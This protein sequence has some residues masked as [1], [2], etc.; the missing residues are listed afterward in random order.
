MAIV[1]ARIAAGD[2]AVAKRGPLDVSATSSSGGGPMALHARALEDV[3]FGLSVAEC[4]AELRQ[5]EVAAASPGAD[6]SRS[7]GGVCVVDENVAKPALPF[8]VWQR[9][10]PAL[11]F[12][13]IWLR[14]MVAHVSCARC[15]ATH[16]CPSGSPLRCDVVES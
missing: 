15:R 14:T 9:F 11:I 12:Y 2:E 5:H 16:W 8:P 10:L 7:R 4:R 13:P 6:S 1:D 3:E